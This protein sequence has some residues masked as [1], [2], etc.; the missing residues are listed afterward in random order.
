MYRAFFMRLHLSQYYYAIYVDPSQG[1]L[2]SYCLK[3]GM[4]G[5][6]IEAFKNYANCV[7]GGN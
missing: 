4:F 5:Q 1:I 6:K 3:N 7:G 2:E